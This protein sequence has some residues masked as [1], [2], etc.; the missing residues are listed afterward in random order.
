MNNEHTMDFNKMKG[1]HV[2]KK[3]WSKKKQTH[4]HMILN[5]D[6]LTNT[7]PRFR[8]GK[9]SIHFLE[10]VS[11]HK[12]QII[13]QKYCYKHTHTHIHTHTHTRTHTHT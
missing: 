11:R 5:K 6:N 10:W 9:N 8:Q 12:N 2:Q 4:K 1:R 7:K 13:F 3:K